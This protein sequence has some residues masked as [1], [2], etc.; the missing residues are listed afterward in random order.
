MNEVE[1]FERLCEEI[2]QQA[3]DAMAHASKGAWLTAKNEMMSARFLASDAQKIASAQQ[4]MH[5]DAANESAKIEKCKHGCVPA[6]C[7]KC[8]PRR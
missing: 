2:I 6:W 7:S 4:S 8:S 5:S 3:N 1:E